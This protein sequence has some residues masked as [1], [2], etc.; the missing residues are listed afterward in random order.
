MPATPKSSKKATDRKD[1]KKPGKAGDKKLNGPKKDGKSGPKTPKMKQMTLLHLAKSPP[2]GSPKKKAR[3]TGMTPKLGKPLPPMGLHLLHYYKE[4]KGKEDKKNA[5]S[6]LISKAAKA[7]SSDD[8][9]RLPEELRDMVQKRWELLE[10]KRRWAAM[11][12]EEKQ[13]EIKKKRKELKE[14]LRLRAKERREVEMLAR[15]ELSRRYEDQEI[16]GG[17]SLPAFRLVDMPEGLPNALFGDV[18]MVVDFLLC[19][20]GL[21]MPEDQ[22]P[23]TAGALMDA[24]AGEDAGFLYLN[25]VLVVLL[26]TL[27]QDELADGY[28][29]LDVPLSEIPLTMHS[30]SELVRLCLRPFDAHGG[31]SVQGSEDL[32]VLGNFDDA[33]TSEFL[34]RLETS[35]VFELNP[36]EK[37]SLLV[38]LCHRILL[39]YSVEDHVDAMQQRSAEL[40]KERLA[41]LKEFNDRKKA[42]KMRRK[43]MEEKGRSIQSRWCCS[44]F[45]IFFNLYWNSSK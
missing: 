3:S 9:G 27:L 11:S 38:A 6:T 34:E 31:E 22:Y 21:L 29:E 33:V 28:G 16:D 26:Q 10:H 8:R 12:E 17:K 20:A 45:V 14:K 18:A 35:E 25:R 36:Q 7:L 43:E 44:K 39:T 15:R 5:M 30:V 42:E 23:I 40:W 19:Y 2:V 32:D 41:T 1:G 4:N 37:A 13:E 24:L